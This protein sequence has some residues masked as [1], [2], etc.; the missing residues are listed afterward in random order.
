MHKCTTFDLERRTAAL[1]PMLRLQSM[2]EARIGELSMPLEQTHQQHGPGLAMPHEEGSDTHRIS[3]ESAAAGGLL[4]LLGG[5]AAA[6][7]KGPVVGHQS[8]TIGAVSRGICNIRL[9]LYDVD[10]RL[11]VLAW[12]VFCTWWAQQKPFKTKGLT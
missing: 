11:Q 6:W 10:I 12:P 2:A 1:D 3:A 8:H 9:P 5:K 7:M 4:A